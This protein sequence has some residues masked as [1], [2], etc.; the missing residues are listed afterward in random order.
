M[1]DQQRNN[2]YWN[3]V[4][5]Y[6]DKNAQREQQKTGGF[7]NA[8]HVRLTYIAEGEPHVCDCHERSQTVS[9]SR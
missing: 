4:K 7:V 1:P 3:K 6:P 5:R 2:S 8:S 9:P